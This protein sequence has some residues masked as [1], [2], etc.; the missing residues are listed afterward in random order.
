V[1][2]DE[3][4]CAFVAPAEIAAAGS[5]AFLEHP[6]DHSVLPTGAT[7]TLT[8]LQARVPVDDAVSALPLLVTQ[9]PVTVEQEPNDV[10]DKAQQ[11]SL[12]LVL[13]GRFNEPRDADWY[14]FDATAGGPHA[15]NVYC[16]RI[17]GYADPYLVIVDEKGNRVQELDD[18]GIRT[19][20]FDAHL[21]DPAGVVNLT[22]GKKYRVLVQDRYRRGGERYQYVLTINQAEPDFYVAAIHSHNPGPGGVNLWRG[23]A[24][25]LDVIVNQEQG[26]NG[27]V[28]IT[29]DGLPAGM[30][31]TPT[32]IRNSNRGV[33]VLRAA[34]DAADFTGPIRL[35]ATGQRGEQPLVR[36][37]RPYTRVWTE[38]N[39]NSSRPMRDLVIAVRD[40]APYRLEWASDSVEV[41][42][43]KKADLKLRLIRRWP[44]F[45]NE[46]TI[47]PLAFPANF[48]MNN[49]SF[50]G[51]QSELAIAIDVQGNTQP[52]EHTLAVLG[53]G[54]VP[55]NKDANAKDR[56][57]T[58]VS[59]P[60]A[61]VTIKVKTA[62]K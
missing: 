13:S 30:H 39:K 7:F 33:F 38:A 18:L 20:A 59:L 8:G 6:T 27:P 10:M 3:L 35:I 16:E 1:S 47:Q 23:G 5:Y 62:A 48:K 60:S 25:Y 28:T 21:R 43:G 41:E 46:V 12:P 2:L 26:Y 42:A 36:Q 50:T 45:K 56:P 40:G 32:V 49:T 17:K 22:A 14:E 53:Q 44:D 15:F 34:D 9:S 51:E 54:Q 37:V 24:V 4:Q 29:A 11:V 58:L 55:F 52:G 57:N 31:A 19:N 61:P